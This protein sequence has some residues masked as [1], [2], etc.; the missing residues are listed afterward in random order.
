MLSNEGGR[1]QVIKRGSP[2]E[3]MLADAYELVLNGWCQGAAATDEYGEPVEPSSALARQ[4][5]ASGALTRIWERHDDPYGEA[6]EAFE[7]A[8]LALA[9]V[10]HDSP[11]DWNDTAGRT[12]WEVLDALALAAHRVSP[13]AA[14]SNG[15]ARSHA[16]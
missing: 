11:Q 9:G 8:N 16:D 7:A 4:W 10:V 12:L 5:S 6:L 13:A 15:R 1:M 2:A 14:A 3:E